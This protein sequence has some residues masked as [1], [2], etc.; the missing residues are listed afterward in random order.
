MEPTGGGGD[1]EWHPSRKWRWRAAVAGNFS[2]TGARV[3][4]EVGGE[5]QFAA[6]GKRVKKTRAE[7]KSIE[8]KSAAQPTETSRSLTHTGTRR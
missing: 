6:T 5:R 3:G 4:G 2:A 7:G 1:S 8:S